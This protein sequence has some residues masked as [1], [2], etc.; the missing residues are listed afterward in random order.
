MSRES[1][2][3]VVSE[4]WRWRRVE[5]LSYWVRSPPHGEEVVDTS[6]LAAL[7]AQDHFMDEITAP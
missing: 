5:C 4:K 1:E 2:I 7:R 6:S 3:L